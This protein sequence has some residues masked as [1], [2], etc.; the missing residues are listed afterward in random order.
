VQVQ[1][2]DVADL[3]RQLRVGGELEG[4]GPPGPDTMFAP[5]ARDGV[6]ADTQLTGQQPV[7]Q[8]VIPSLAGGG[9]RVTDKI[10]ARRARRTVCGRPGRGRS[11]RP[12]SPRRA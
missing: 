5:D 2:D 9:L 4:L 3:G 12:G 11:G 7:D 8:W 6:T 10:S 1:A